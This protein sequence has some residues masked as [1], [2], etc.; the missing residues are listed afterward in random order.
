MLKDQQSLIIGVSFW[1]LNVVLGSFAWDSLSFVQE[2]GCGLFGC[3]Q[4]VKFV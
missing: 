4:V 3:C 2:G 1:G